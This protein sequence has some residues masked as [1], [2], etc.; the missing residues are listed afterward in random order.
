LPRLLALSALL[1]AIGC[2]T[3]HSQLLEPRIAEPDINR[4]AL[5][6]V[7]PQRLPSPRTA[8]ATLEWGGPVVATTATFDV[9]SPEEID[10]DLVDAFGTP[11]LSV[12]RDLL[13]YTVAASTPRVERTL[14]GIG[15]ILALWLLGSCESGVVWQGFNAVAVDCAASGP[16][17]GLIWRIWVDPQ[18]GARTRGELLKGDRLLGDFI[19]DPT[20]R[21]VL[22]DP[23]RGYALRI[24]PSALHD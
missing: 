2:A 14:D 12:R 13:T 4:L 17:A 23:S 6:A 11:V 22:Q 8:D 3:L 10:V 19:C 21:C 5:E 20:G 1:P 7:S 24:Q 16:D 18:Q 9:R 15:R